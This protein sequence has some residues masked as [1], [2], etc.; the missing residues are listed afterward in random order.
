[1]D[2]DQNGQEDYLCETTAGSQMSYRG[3][4]SKC[5]ALTTDGDAPKNAESRHCVTM[6]TTTTPRPD[7]YVS[8]WQK[9]GPYTCTQGNVSA[10][11]STNTIIEDYSVLKPAGDTTTGQ[12]SNGVYF[13]S[14][15]LKFQIDEKVWVNFDYPIKGPIP[16]ELDGIAYFKQITHNGPYASLSPFKYRVH[17]K[18]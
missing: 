14:S 8:E 3:F 16:P 12:D 15:V 6:I 5:A 10:V 9:G 1:M 17:L 13:S 18:S 4:Y 11:Y 2:C 7:S